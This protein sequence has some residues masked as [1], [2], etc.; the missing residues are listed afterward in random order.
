MDNRAAAVSLPRQN[1]KIR[2]QGIA[3]TMLI[4]LWA[5][6]ME[7]QSA[8][9][10]IISDPKAVEMLG[11]IDYDFSKFERGRLTQVGVA[12]R[13]L[14]FDEFVR[15]FLARHEEAAIVNLG[16]GLDTRRH[17]LAPGKARWY[18]VD[19][20]EAMAWRRVFFSEDAGCRFIE[21]SIFDYS[22]MDD[23]EAGLPLLLLAEGLFMYFPEKRLRPLFQ[24][25]AER[26]PGADLYFE[27]LAPIMVGK[28][29]KHDTVKMTASI[30]EFLWGIQHSAD[31]N[32]WSPNIRFVDEW[33]YFDYQKKRWGPL[34]IVA[35]LPLLRPLFASR[36][37]H[38]RFDAGQS[39]ARTA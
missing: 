29:R 32:A 23:V 35:R 22:W 6:A 21:K 2:L 8:H 19:L 28:S 3:E 20:P 11:Q 37:V 17:R 27:M 39:Q 31:L 4:P 9:R 12:V 16:A 26:F 18:D 36:I 14:L 13:T 1:G 7:T 10:P 33:N 5:K 24:A 34:G 30:P 25:M 15:A 38:V